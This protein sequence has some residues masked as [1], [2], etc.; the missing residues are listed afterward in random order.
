[1][2]SIPKLTRAVLEG[3][4]RTT[5][6]QSRNWSKAHVFQVEWPPGGG[7]PVVIKDMIATPLWFRIVVG[8]AILRREVRALRLLRDVEGVPRLVARVDADAIAME[9]APGRPLSSFAEQECGPQVLASIERLLKQVHARG[10]AHA[11]LHAHNILVDES[12]ATSLID[13]ATASAFRRGSFG[14]ERWT[15]EQW[16]MLDR[17]SLAKIKVAHAPQMLSSS[18]RDLLLHGGSGVYRAVKAVRR[19]MDRLRGKRRSASSALEQFVAREQ[20]AR[21]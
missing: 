20:E 6:H 14:F 18:E 5:L 8:R 17:R 4:P 10:L 12:G 13:W 3:L 9:K 11:D 16:K 7:R 15:F 1:M 19:R 2:P 21:K